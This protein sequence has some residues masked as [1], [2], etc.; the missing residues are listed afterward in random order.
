MS[1]RILFLV[2]LSLAATLLLCVAGIITLA[3]AERGTPDIL[4]ATTT[5]IVG[6]LVGILVPRESAGKSETPDTLPDHRLDT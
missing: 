4:V 1:P 3:W 2:V 6:A 5:L